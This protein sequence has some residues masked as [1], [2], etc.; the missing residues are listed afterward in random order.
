MADLER[1]EGRENMVAPLGVA[2][3]YRSCPEAAFDFETTG[4]LASLAPLEGHSRAREALDFAA[5]MRREG[6]NPFLLGLPGHD[7]LALARR[8]F[9]EHARQAP[10][11]PDWCY[12][13]NDDD[14]D[15]PLHLAV[16]GG[17]GRQLR[18]DVDRL[19]AELGQAIP[20]AFSH[21]DFRNHL[22]ELQEARGD[23][24]VP[25]PAWQVRERIHAYTLETLQAT[26]DPPLS[27]RE[28]TYR[29][30]PGVLEHL[31]A[32]RA[33]ILEHAESF[34]SQTPEIT[35]AVLF[36]RYRIHP[37]VD[38]RAAEGA[39]VIHEALPTHAHLV[40]RIEHRLREGTLSSDVSLIRAGAL[41]RANGGYLLLDGRVLLNQ[42]GAWETLKR[43]LRAGEIGM[44]S[45][46]QAQG[47]GVVPFLSPQPI[48]LDIK[49]VLLGDRLLYYKL[50]DEDPEF[51]ELFKVQ[52]D[53]EDDL[54]RDD[55]RLAHYARLIATLARE[56]GLRP[57]DRGGVA[58]VIERA[59]RLANDQTK[60]TARHRDLEDLM[61]EADYLAGA[62]DSSLITR[63]QV[64]R[65]LERQHWRAGRIREQSH[66]LLTRGTLVISTRG[67]VSGQING[68]SVL[69]IGTLVFGQPSR[70]TA[71]ARPG[72]DQVVDIERESHLGGRVHSK[73]VMILSRYLANRY[74]R[75]R[76][77]SLSASLALE[78]SYGGTE[79]DSA[80]VAEVCVLVSAIARAGLDQAFAVTGSIN[81]HGEVQSVGGVNEKIEA[82]FDVCRGLGPL[83]GQGVIMPA[84]NV[85]NL[86][87]K[88][89]VREAIAAGTFHIHAV[90]HVDEAL[91]LLTGMTVGKADA[92]GDFPAESLNGQVQA[93]LA[94]FAKVVKDAHENTVVVDLSHEEKG[95]SSEGE[96]GLEE[97]FDS[98]EKAP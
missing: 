55:A 59:S 62:D 40:G 18:S 53:L 74:A 82:F 19:L 17:T 63:D 77:L 56:A 24:R 84:A 22:Q 83:E 69:Q 94:S 6:F 71:T 16:P 13:H 43:V 7:R 57:L 92:R 89:V 9:E 98:G 28:A 33:A 85:E 27:E 5:A 76:M 4:E 51:L 8:F 78:Q 70:I 10:S 35:P 64:E 14:P 32:L 79:G 15:R 45:L 41:H 38:N 96:E 54:V 20:A 47:A 39:P 73:A 3:V 66:E 86:M 95:E 46:D 61:L 49:V 58:A 87:L 75:D 29:G 25:L 12:R 52:A 34:V 37:L 91:A 50:C 60:L 65:A 36:A 67:R 68:L 2:Q 93:R 48:P 11:P 80:S 23:R 1:L 97:D 81:Q 21:N 31:A 88:R 90:Q 26:I 42:P 30:Q 72:H 44:D